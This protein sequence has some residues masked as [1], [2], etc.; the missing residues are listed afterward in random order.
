[1]G[2]PVRIC[3][4]EVRRAI[5]RVEDPSTT[6]LPD[7]AFFAE[8]SVA[9]TAGSQFLDKQALNCKIGL[10][11]RRTVAL[12]PC[13]DGPVKEFE[14]KRGRTIGDLKRSREIVIQGRHGSNL[15]SLR[16]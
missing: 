11:D 10:R 13:L 15:P 12:Q 9:R 4:C 14:R 6:A 7:G 5:D 3:T 1:M 16:V 8:D 2:A